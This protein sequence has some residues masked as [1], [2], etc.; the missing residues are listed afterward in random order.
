MPFS[1][2]N[3]TKKRDNTTLHLL[4][5]RPALPVSRAA[6]RCNLLGAG[7]G[8]VLSDILLML[9]IG[10]GKVNFFVVTGQEKQ[11][12]SRGWVGDRPQRA[13]GHITDWPRWQALMDARI[14]WRLNIN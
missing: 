12:I 14:I 5:G 10:V 7:F 1:A 9:L 2:L 13:F 8:A 6:M 3:Y 4:A 11:I